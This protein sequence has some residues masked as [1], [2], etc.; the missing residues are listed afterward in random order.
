MTGSIATQRVEAGAIVRFLAPGSRNSEG[1][2]RLIPAVVI[3]QWPDGSLQLY[4]LH[5]EGSFLVNA[6]PPDAVEM[7]LSRMELDAILDGIGRRLTE[8]ENQVASMSDWK[9]RANEPRFTLADG[10]R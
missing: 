6:I 3:G 1:Q 7:V 5:F 9:P 2:Q 4:A 8:L 10:S